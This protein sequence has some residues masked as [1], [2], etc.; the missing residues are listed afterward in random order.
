MFKSISIKELRELKE[1]ITIID[2]RNTEKYNTSHIE[3]AINIPSEKLIIE[4]QKY[5]KKEKTYCIYCQ[6]GITSF[7][8]CTILSKLD[9]NIINLKGGYESYI[10]N[11]GN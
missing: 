1:K 11:R 9:Y 10:L 7:N 8:T 3:N 4:P 6:K 2:I 5:L